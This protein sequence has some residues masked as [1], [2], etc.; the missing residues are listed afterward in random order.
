VVSELKAESRNDKPKQKKKM[1][2]SET[3]KR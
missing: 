1:L 3:L 2:K